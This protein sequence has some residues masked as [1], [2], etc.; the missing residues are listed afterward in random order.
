[1]TTAVGAS[2]RLPCAARPGVVRRNSLRSLR[3]LR[4]DRAPQVRSTKRASRADPGA[5]LLGAADIA[6]P[7][8]G[9][10]AVRCPRPPETRRPPARPAAECRCGNVGGARI[11]D[12]AVACEQQR[13]Y[14]QRRGRG[15]GQRRG[16]S[17]AGVPC[18]QP[19]SAA[20]PAARAARIVHHSRGDCP[21]AARV[22]SVASF[23]AP[24]GAASI[25]GNPREAGASTR[26]ACGRGPAPLPAP[27][28][29][30]SAAPLPAQWIARNPRL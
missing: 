22:A 27:L 1:M 8:L 28:P 23:A 9:H 29:A 11:E 15:R 20:A 17:A 2:H 3:E 4:S 24:A 14:R 16:P 13:R 26:R 6:A 30:P 25:A 7:R 5:T 18:A 12:G 21:S 19:R 10:R